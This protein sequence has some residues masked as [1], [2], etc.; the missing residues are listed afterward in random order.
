MN[1]RPLRPVEPT[2]LA[3]ADRREA[4]LDAALALVAEGDVDGVSIESV[5]DQ[6]GV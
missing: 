2:R 4:L 3:R 5:A 6:A 1:R